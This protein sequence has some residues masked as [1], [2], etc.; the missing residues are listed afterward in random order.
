MAGNTKGGDQVASRGKLPRV[1]ASIRQTLY[2]SQAEL[3]KAS[4]LSRQLLS[5]YETG[6][7]EPTIHSLDSWLLGVKLVVN[8]LRGGKPK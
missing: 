3:G 6:V 5:Y 7:L 8:N 1:M 2:L 4:G